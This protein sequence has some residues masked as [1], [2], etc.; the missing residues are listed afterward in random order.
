MMEKFCSIEYLYKMSRKI[1]LISPASTI[2][3]VCLKFQVLC[4]EGIVALQSVN[5]NFFVE[6][7]I[8]SYILTLLFKTTQ[9]LILE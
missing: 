9:N 2:F 4:I 6:L 5:L 7:Q 3:F 1:R 8:C